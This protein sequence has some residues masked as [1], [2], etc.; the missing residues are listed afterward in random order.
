MTEPANADQIAFWNG[1][2]GLKWTEFRSDMD[3]NL[4]DASAGVLNL[5]RARSGERVLDI[6]CGAGQTTRILANA[7]SPGGQVTGVDIS[8]PLL[9]VARAASASVHNVEFI[10]AD[11]AFQAF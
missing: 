7:V 10:E 5:A 9:A 3:R 1:A 4:Q 11:A 8:A 6:G 2:T